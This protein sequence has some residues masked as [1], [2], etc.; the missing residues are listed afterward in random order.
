[1]MLIAVLTLASASNPISKVLQLLSE[2]QQK[3]LKE[4]EAEQKQYEA[5]AEWCEDTAVAKQYEIKDGKA[6]VERLSA[7]IEK[8]GATISNA[9]TKIAELAATISTNEA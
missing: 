4:G 1:M 8:E 7:T 2:L 6:A 9:E 3:V 5:F